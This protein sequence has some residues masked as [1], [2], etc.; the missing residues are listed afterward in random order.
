MNK[1]AIRSLY[2]ELPGLVARGILTPD[3]AER[4][5]AH[6]GPVEPARPVKLAVII[7]GVLGSLLIGAGIILILAHNWEDLSR[8]ARAILSFL[9]LL[10]AQGLAVWTLLKM[11]DSIAWREG[12]STLVFL[13]IGASISLVAQTYN[14]SGDLPGFILT[15]SLLGLPL[16]YIFNAVVP[17][18]LYLWGITEWACHLRYEDSF[19]AGYWLLAALLLPQLALWMKAG[20][21]RTRP[22]LLLWAICVSTTVAAGVTIERVLPGLWIILYSALFA[23]MFLAGEFWFSES[24]GF[25]PRPL[26]HFGAGGVLVLSFLLT[27]EWPWHS[28]GWRHWQWERLHDTAWRAIPDAAL[29][30]LIPLAA[31]ILLVT[32]VRRKAPLG[33][34]FGLA[35]IIA[36]VGYCLSSLSES[37]APAAGLFDLYLLVIG[38]WLIVAGIRVN[39][40]GQM[41]VGL[42]AVM[43]LIIARFFDNDLSFLLRGLIF[44]ALG[45]ALLMANIFMLRRKRGEP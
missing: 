39:K 19:N 37:Y 45:I 4:L 43:A 15:W 40:Q 34:L 13:M 7:F 1:K 14:I 8:P 29:G 12:A 22:T 23:L 26:R 44:I 21:Y 42:L 41:N 2:D 33:L 25:W 16:V 9:P 31:I 5:R 27:F 36:T 18:L 32:T 35:P 11:R 30:A 20:R 6:Y 24:G 3:A 28:I 17:A 38:L 10:L